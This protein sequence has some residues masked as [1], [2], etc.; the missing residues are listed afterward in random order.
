MSAGRRHQN[1]PAQPINNA[2]PYSTAKAHICKP[3]DQQ[4]VWL[5]KVGKAVSV[6]YHD[7]IKRIYRKIVKKNAPMF[8][9]NQ[10]RLGL[11]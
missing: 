8:R 6:T 10:R 1:A 7:N 5:E 2:S 9:L 3:K 4:P 11:H